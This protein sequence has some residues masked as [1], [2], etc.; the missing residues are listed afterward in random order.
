MKSDCNKEIRYS[1]LKAYF[2]GG[3]SEETKEVI[4]SW[5]EEK[6]QPFKLEKCLKEIW[7]ETDPAKASPPG[8]HDRI[9]DRIHHRINLLNAAESPVKKRPTDKS[10]IRLTTILKQASR[11]AAIIMLPVL[12]YLGWEWMDNRRWQD[13]QSGIVYNEIVCPLGAR[14]RF[15][16][17][18][19]TTGWL[20]NGSRLKYPVIFTGNTRQVDLEGEAYFD[21]TPEKDRPF[22]INTDR[23]D[24]KVLGT[25]LN[26]YA[27]PDDKYQSFTLEEGAIELITMKDGKEVPVMKM[28]PGQ[29]A[30]YS[31]SEEKLDMFSSDPLTKTIILDREVREKM[32]ERDPRSAAGEMDVLNGRI[33][34]GSG[35]T[36]HYTNWKEGKLVLRNDPMPV[37]LKRIE[38][39]YRIKFIVTD[40][41]INNYRYWATFQEENLEQVLRMLSLTGPITFKKRPRVQSP[42][43]TFMTQ[44]IEVILNK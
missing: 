40:E 12:V 27:Y 1:F 38:R 28:K 17:P 19:G 36:E 8:G 15:E 3:P 2:E 16:L 33:S 34:V 37:M 42:D 20:N 30:V 39:W 6:D 24:V 14:S 9:L 5:F 7:N 18:D 11:V 21:V 43:G 10:G 26:V 4:A 41:R 29:H 23:L 35:D 25:R 22:I 32:E 44:E 13:S 31:T